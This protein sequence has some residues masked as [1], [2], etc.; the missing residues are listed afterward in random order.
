MSLQDHKK[1]SNCAYLQEHKN[2]INQ[3]IK[4]VGETCKMIAHKN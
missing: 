2:T 1:N 4:Q 3:R